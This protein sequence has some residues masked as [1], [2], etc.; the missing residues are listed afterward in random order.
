MNNEK[1]RK[2]PVLR[3]KGFTDD[4][5]LHKWKNILLVNSGKDYKHLHKGSIPVYGTGGYMLSVDKELSNEDAI[6]IGRKGTIDHPQYLKAPFW[7]VDTLFFMT[8]K[9]DININFAFALSQTINWKKYDESTGLPSLSK[10]SINSISVKIPKYNEQKEIGNLISQI[11]KLLALQQRKLD[12][13]KKLKESYMFQIFPTKKQHKSN[14]K[15]MEST[16]S[17]IKMK[18]GD[19]ITHRSGTAIE[20]YFS[21]KGKYKVISIGSYGS[22]GQ[23][24]DQGIRAIENEKTKSYLVNKEELTMVL[25]DK[26]NGKIL[27]R[28]LLIKE[29]NKYVVNQRSE[30]IKLSPIFWDPQFAFT[31]LNGPFRKE[32]IRIMQGGTQRYV[33]FSSVEKLMVILPS[34]KEQQKI[35]LSLKKINSLIKNQNEK[36]SSLKQTKKFLLQNLFI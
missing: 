35:G 8:P 4:W 28:V 34:V 11:E 36:I 6:G 22:D 25:N 2:A 32:I 9:K 33:N 5:E 30:I 31:Y 23:Y 14:L 17:L 1:Q 29:N 20:K 12:G 7:T 19:T 18:F 27:G 24:I 10:N 3:F 15:F 16:N 21:S 13:L 26:T